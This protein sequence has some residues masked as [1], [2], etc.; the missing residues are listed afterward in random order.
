MRVRESGPA[1]NLQIT[2]REMGQIDID[3]V[4]AF[5][6]SPRVLKGIKKELGQ[7]KDVSH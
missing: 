6:F 4:P 1:R 2:H 5:T 7:S 3:L